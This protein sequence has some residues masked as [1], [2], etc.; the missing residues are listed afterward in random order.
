MDLDK[1]TKLKINKL[2]NDKK[3]ITYDKFEELFKKYSNKE[4]CLIVNI[5]N[6]KGIDLI[7]EEIEVV[8]LLDE[9][10]SIREEN[11]ED[12]NK[13]FVY[14]E[15]RNYYGNSTK[16]NLKKAHEIFNFLEEDKKNKII[17]FL[18]I[19]GY[20][21]VENDIVESPELNKENYKNIDTKF[22]VS[23][24]QK[25]NE[26]YLDIIIE[27]NINLIRSRVYKLNNYLKNTFEDEDLIQEGI[28]GLKK[29]V[30]KFNL[31]EDTAFSTYAIPWIDQVIRRAIMD[32]GSLIRIPVHTYE[33][34]FEILKKVNSE[35]IT[36]E[37]ILP[38]LN[39][40]LQKSKFYLSLIRNYVKISS[41]DS[42]VDG[43]DDLRL[44]DLIIDESVEDPQLNLE[45]EEFIKFVYESIDKKIQ[46]DILIKRF[47]LEGQ[48]P[49]TLE[50]IAKD[51]NITRERV[52]QIENKTLKKLKNRAS[53]LKYFGGNIL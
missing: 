16:I 2:V 38:I 50:K 25:G 22:L 1:I 19:N 4:K 49:M 10:N 17:K 27:N 42:I 28:I 33:K 52:R 44:A 7:D 47:G 43:T 30:E 14:E 32:K 35:N 31:S 9:N 34:I 18:K 23:E 12:I 11:F 36:L 20:E 39:N 6:K 29:A 45:R 21:F 8:N 48:E 53:Y 41:Y 15:I 51:Y 5:L 13:E 46:K 26:K 40:D 24:Y 37:K 3:N